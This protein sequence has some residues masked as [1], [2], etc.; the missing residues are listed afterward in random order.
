MKVL[1]DARYGSNLKPSRIEVI[2][3]KLRINPTFH[4]FSKTSYYFSERFKVVKNNRG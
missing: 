1:L 3:D 4:F 2:Y